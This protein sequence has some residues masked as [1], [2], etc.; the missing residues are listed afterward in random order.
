M[1]CL[2]CIIGL[3]FLLITT[4]SDSEKK[5]GWGIVGFFAFLLAL[6]EMG[7]SGEDAATLLV[8]IGVVAFIA[9]I[10]FA[11]VNNSNTKT[12]HI[13]KE[14]LSSNKEI[15]SVK[16]VTIE[17]FEKQNVSRN[18]E[19]PS[20]KTVTVEP[21]EKQFA[22]MKKQVD[23]VC[24]M[25][26]QMSELVCVEKSEE[27]EP[28]INEKVHKCETRRKVEYYD[29][30]E[31][32]LNLMEI[33]KEY[34]KIMIACIQQTDIKECPGLIWKDKEMLYVLPLEKDAQ[35]YSW[36]LTSVPIIMYEEQNNPDIDEEYMD[37]SQQKIAKEFEGLFPEYL[38]GE[39]G[40]YTGKYV[41]PIGL[42]VTSTSGKILF[43]LLSAKFHVVDNV[44]Q[45]TRYA[46]EIK[47]LYQRKI[48][49]DTGVISYKQYSDERESIISTYQIS[50]KNE[51]RYAE[52]MQEAKELGLL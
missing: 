21:F 44:T 24:D 31:E 50:E 8:V 15:P 51:K 4:G 10:V 6:S 30:V 49:R 16:A 27:K 23:E 22:K 38:F 25:N 46:K 28:L 5:F 35:I 40:V 19:I 37:V 26:I 36:P 18:K 39:N 3:P 14:N 20:V 17:S 9:L 45:S 1:G 48:L 7:V 32:L 42:E 12:D 41:L 52:Q 29:S 11:I 47:E 2:G 43:E 13:E 33:P 34:E